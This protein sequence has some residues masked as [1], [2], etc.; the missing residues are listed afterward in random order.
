M[1][2]S[3]KNKI[4]NLKKQL[5]FHTQME[6]KSMIANLTARIEKLESKVC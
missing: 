2:T 1:K 4:E 6:N 3:I 5:W